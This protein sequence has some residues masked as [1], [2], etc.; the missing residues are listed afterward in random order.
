MENKKTVVQVINEIVKIEFIALLRY[1][2]RCRIT[3]TNNRIID[4]DFYPIGNNKNLE[5][6]QFEAFR[7]ALDKLQ[8]FYGVIFDLSIQA[9][10]WARYI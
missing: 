2:C 1:G 6:S 8:E 4:H 7:F 5:F 3:L 9:M 10:L